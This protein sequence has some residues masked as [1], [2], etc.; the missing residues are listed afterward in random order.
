[1][2]YLNEHCGTCGCSE[3]SHR[4]KQL[5]CDEECADDCEGEHESSWEYPCDECEFCEDFL[6]MDDPYAQVC[7]CGCLVEEHESV[8]ID[9]FDDDADADADDESD[10]D[11]ADDELLPSTTRIEC[12]CGNCAL[13]TPDGP[14]Y[15]AV[16]EAAELRRER[17]WP[18]GDSGLQV[19]DRLV[20]Q[21][22][23]DFIDEVLTVD[24]AIV[25]VDGVVQRIDGP[26]PAGTKV[27]L[28]LAETGE[29]LPV[30]LTWIDIEWTAP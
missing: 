14:V 30:A 8:A 4:P 1:M 20:S 6:T 7:R 24:A 3:E 25:V 28:F 17:R 19:T 12:P 29:G 5:D 11:A 22:S 2:F 10:D 13:V 21:V 15:V 18:L 9:L 26:V 27:A 16:A 23:T